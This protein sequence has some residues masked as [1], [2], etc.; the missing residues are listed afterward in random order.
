[1]SKNNE[2]ELFTLAPGVLVE[3]DA[4]R[5]IKQTFAYLARNN[6]QTGRR[7]LTALHQTL[8]QLAEMPHLGAPRQFAHPAL[9]GL[10]QWPVKDFK[11]YLIFYRPFASG[12]GLEVLRILHTSRDVAVHLEDSQESKTEE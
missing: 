1:M 10:R 11:N 6:P 5:D 12:N 3:A 7:F 4:R 2:S 8:T 9:H